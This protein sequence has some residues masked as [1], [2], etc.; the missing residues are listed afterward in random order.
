MST[1]I[2]WFQQ[3]QVL[4]DEDP[5]EVEHNQD[6][7]TLPETSHSTYNEEFPSHQSWTQGM[8]GPK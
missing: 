1:P 2:E 7:Q 5:L 8:L 4:S 3:Q 6:Y